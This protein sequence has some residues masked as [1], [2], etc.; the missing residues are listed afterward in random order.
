MITVGDSGSLSLMEALRDSE[1][2]K[3]GCGGSCQ[4]SISMSTIVYMGHTNYSSLSSQLHFQ[5][6]AM[7]LMTVGASG[8]L[9]LMEALQ[10]SEM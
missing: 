2:Q 7:V 5:W 3:L 8:I 1:I 4:T 10:D 6:Q 9:S